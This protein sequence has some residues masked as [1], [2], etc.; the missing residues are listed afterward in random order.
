[1]PLLGLTAILLLQGG[2]PLREPLRGQLAVF[3]F[4]ALG[5]ALKIPALWIGDAVRDQ[6]HALP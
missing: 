2:H 4:A 6:S 5:Q 3:C 1:M